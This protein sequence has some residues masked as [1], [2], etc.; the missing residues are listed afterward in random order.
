MTIAKKLRRY[1]PAAEEFAYDEFPFYWL[2]RVQGVYQQQMERVLK[3]IGTDIPTWRVLF[4]LKVHGRLGVS[5]IADH[6]IVKLS[7]MTRMVQR[8]RDEG[9]VETAPH[10]DD[11]RV[12]EV[13]VTPAGQAL[14]A[15]IEDAT[16][17]LFAHSFDGMT[18][19]QIARLNEALR[20]LHDNLA[21]L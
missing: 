21:S 8:M 7:T 1:I 4:I 9:L 6:A 3:K 19:P 17:R 20:Q 16:S 14:T 13:V 5:E 18:E 11:A 12:T 15:A 10:P 2:A